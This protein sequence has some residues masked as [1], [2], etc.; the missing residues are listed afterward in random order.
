MFHSFEDEARDDENAA[1]AKQLREW[2]Y[3]P[4]WLTGPQRQEGDPYVI[5]VPKGRVKLRAQSKP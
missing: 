2:G 3:E 1:A 4:R 5:W